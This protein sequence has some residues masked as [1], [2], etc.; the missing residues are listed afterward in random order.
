ML[1]GCQTVDP[2]H[3]ASDLGLYFLLRYVCIHRVN[4]VNTQAKTYLSCP[5]PHGCLG[6]AALRFVFVPGLFSHLF[7]FFFFCI[8]RLLCHV[9]TLKSLPVHLF[10]GVIVS[11]ARVYTLQSPF[12]FLFLMGVWEGLRFVIVALPGLFS[13]LF[14]LH[15]MP[16]VFVPCGDPRKSSRTFI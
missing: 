15:T 6:R 2:D 5:L 12:V 9:E 13:Y 16:V 3:L 1:D 11:S 8:P 7:F 14:F 4:T 10:N